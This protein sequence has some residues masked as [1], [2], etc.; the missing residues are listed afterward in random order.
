MMISALL[1]VIFHLWIN[2]TNYP[3]E[4]VIR[5]LCVVGVDIFFFV[6]LYGISKKKIVYKDFIKNRF[7]SVY[8]KFIIF[9]LIIS[10]ISSWSIDKLLLTLLGIDLFIKGGGSFLWFIPGIMIIYLLIPLY[11]KLDDK[12]SIITLS[13]SLI[14]FLVFSILVSYYT[15]YNE[16]FILTNRIPIMLIGYYLGKYDFTKNISKCMY[17]IIMFLLLI[18]GSIISYNITLNPFK[19]DYFYDLFYILNIPFELGLILLFNLVKTNSVS[20]ILGSVTLE[21]YAFQMMFGFKIANFIYN[22]VNNALLTNIIVIAFL[23]VIS[24]IFKYIYDF[25]YN[26]IKGKL[27]KV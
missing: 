24:I 17:L 21:L 13:I 19:T 14:V 1:I 18:V 10:F 25:I 11:K 15:S 16:I 23:I 9:V 26:F 2:V 12:N 5:Q 8:L 4:R 20:N 27:K 3:C 7:I 22:I 6:S